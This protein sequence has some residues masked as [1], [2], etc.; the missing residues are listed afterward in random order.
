MAITTQTERAGRL[1]DEAKSLLTTS[2]VDAQIKLQE[3]LQ[4]TANG[5]APVLHALAKSLQ[6]QCHIVCGDRPRAIAVG[7]EALT[8]LRAVP[9]SLEAA[10]LERVLMTALGTPVPVA[11]GSLAYV[12]DRDGNVVPLT[13]EMLGIETV[14]V[15][16]VAADMPLAA[17]EREPNI[18][19]EIGQ[20]IAG[21]AM[22]TGTGVA[23]SFTEGLKIAG[24]QAI[25]DK[26]VKVVH[27]KLGHNL[28]IANTPLGQQVERLMF[29]ALLH[30]IVDAMPAGKLPGAEMIKRNCMRAVTGVA[31]DDGT[32][33]INALLPIL[34]EVAKMGTAEGGFDILTSMMGGATVEQVADRA[35]APHSEIGALSEAL[36]RGLEQ[37]A[38][39]EEVEVKLV[40]KKNGKLAESVVPPFEANPTR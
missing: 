15:G 5:V 37:A 11:H 4:I 8:E 2:V 30:F 34:G 13:T 6:A 33:L 20:K 12:T 39:G 36:A 26:I 31:K 32:A 3:A 18:M 7:A 29:P 24:S 1:L 17:A 10:K 25:S 38:P 21:A 22:S 19:A 40:V 16:A 14:K 28:P 27:D 35:I 23:E 9:L